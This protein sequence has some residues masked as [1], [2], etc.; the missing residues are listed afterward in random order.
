M[1]DKTKMLSRRKVDLDA[2]MRGLAIAKYDADSRGFSGG[3]FNPEP[4]EVVFSLYAWMIKSLASTNDDLYGL[5]PGPVRANWRMDMRHRVLTMLLAGGVVDEWRRIVGIEPLHLI[6]IQGP[7][8]KGWTNLDAEL[9]AL[10]DLTYRKLAVH[11]N[12]THSDAI[13]VVDTELRLNKETGRWFAQ[14]TYGVD[15]SVWRSDYRWMQSKSKRYP[16]SDILQ[17]EQKQ[18]EPLIWFVRRAKAQFETLLVPESES[19]K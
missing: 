13:N 1:K 6:W 10:F 18:G 8:P 5:A 12:T 7:F 3:T 17:P 19:T 2:L 11:L 16:R 9:D 15:G 14:M 4:T